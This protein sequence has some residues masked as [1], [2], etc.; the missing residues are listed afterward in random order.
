[1]KGRLATGCGCLALVAGVFFWPLLFFTS[2]GA[3]TS[4]DTGGGDAPPAPNEV[5]VAKGPL[6]APAV[7]CQQAVTELA[8][9]PSTFFPDDFVTPPGECTSWA[10]ALWPGHRGRGVSWWGDAWEWY[11]SAAA[12]GYAVSATPSV[13]AIVVFARG[14]TSASAFGH[15]AVVVTIQGTGV[16]VTEMNYAGR[17][18]V[19]L[20][21][22][23]VK[24]PQIVG[25]IPVPEDA[26]P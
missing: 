3:A 18:I 21:T 7:G 1:M 26:I 5:I 23:W 19:D 13:G 14:N 12:Q 2:G 15:V 16:R 10:A 24:D 17:F 9:V 8:Y 6:C 4:T 20:R 11:G 22:V 25:Y